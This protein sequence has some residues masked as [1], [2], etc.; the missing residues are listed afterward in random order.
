[1]I[2]DNALALS[3]L[4]VGRVGGPSVKPYEVA[5]SFKPSNPGKGDDLYRRSVYTWWKR[6]GPAPVMMTLNASKRDVCR[7]RREVTP[8][9][10]QAFVLLNGPQFMEASRV[11]AANLLRK[12]KDNPDSLITEAYRSFTS[13]AARP[14]EF[15]ILRALYDEQLAHYQAN[16]S[17]AK[18]FLG[19]GASPEPK[20]LPTPRVAAATILVNAIMNLDEA[21]SKR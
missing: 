9:P 11:M 16:P 19:T 21:V 4:L 10:L 3:N 13:R 7:V 2:R 17:E 8:S 6:T 20:D 1:M 15:R 5:V 12:H 14:T 18:G